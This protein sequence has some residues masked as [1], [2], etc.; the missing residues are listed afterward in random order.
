MNARPSTK[1]K[2]LVRPFAERFADLILEVRDLD[3]DDLRTLVECEQEFTETNCWYFDY[4]MVRQLASEA[5]YAL[6]TAAP[7]PPQ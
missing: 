5:R 2:D 6:R 3:P 4:W 7:L 1:A